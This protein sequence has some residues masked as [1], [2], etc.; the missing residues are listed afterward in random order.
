VEAKPL[1]RTQ[2]HQVSAEPDP[3]ACR[4]R[5]AVLRPFGDQRS[6]LLQGQAPYL[7]ES[8]QPRLQPLPHAT[9]SA[10]SAVAKTLKSA[11]QIYK[12]IHGFELPVELDPAT[13]VSL[14]KQIGD[15][16]HGEV[17]EMQ[18]YGQPKIYKR[19]KDDDSWP[20]ELDPD[21]AVKGEAKLLRT[22]EATASFLH[23]AEKKVL[24]AP[25]HFVVSET[26]AAGLRRDFI[27]EVGDKEF[28]AWAKHRLSLNS[29]TAGKQTPGYSLEIIGVIQDRAKGVDLFEYLGDEYD[30]PGTIAREDVKQ[31]ALGLLHAI[32]VLG[33]RGFVH[34]DIK[35][36][37]AFYDQTSKKLMLIDTGGLSKLSKIEA[38]LSDTAFTP[39]RGSTYAY[40]IQDDGA[41][42]L[43]ADLYSVGILLLELSARCETDVSTRDAEIDKI[44][45]LQKSFGKYAKATEGG[46]YDP[47]TA[48]NEVWFKLYGQYQKKN[49]P[50][51]KAGLRAVAHALDM[52]N[53]A[54][55]ANK[56][57]NR[58]SYLSEL[59][60]IASIIR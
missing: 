50:L 59:K 30:N 43:E 38:R 1:R 2:P 56:I 46:G 11:S 17:F 15:G 35:F 32:E 12:G 9:P 49:T 14:V 47:G 5:S 28:R 51:E 53:A 42:G 45:A 20:L 22:Q 52:S 54:T 40:R 39:D 34:G 3:Q 29:D 6:L 31:I 48:R 19:F 27:V 25:T 44:K 57:S 13:D 16:G 60:K 37:N 26:D 8:R 4:L 21:F 58:A 41:S 10:Q 55:H 23:E 36:E 7:Y 33:K 24:V 18:L